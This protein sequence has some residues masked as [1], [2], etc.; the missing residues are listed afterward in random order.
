M[1]SVKERVDKHK[2]FDFIFRTQK[3]NDIL[4]GMICPIDSII[5]DEKYMSDKR[6]YSCP[7]CKGLWLDT[8]TFSYLT[9]ILMNDAFPEQ[10][11]E[12][13]VLVQN[14]KYK[15][16][17]EED[18]LHCPQHTSIS[19]QK[20]YFSGNSRISIDTCS[21]CAGIWIEGH[22]LKMMQ[23]FLTLNPLQM[24][25]LTMSRETLREESKRRKAQ[26][27]LENFAVQAVS[28][29]VNPQMLGLF[30]LRQITQLIVNDLRKR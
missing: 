25:A 12:W 28:Y 21:V 6:L 9:N 30:L 22:E 8:D 5:L 16:L 24:A 18:T 15:F 20:H 3:N 10:F 19:M 7:T 13:T 29:S 26:E 11:T 2:H 4:G 14:K 27:S 23:D 1:C 17:W